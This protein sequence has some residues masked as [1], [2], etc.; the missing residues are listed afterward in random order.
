M[1]NDSSGARQPAGPISGG[2]GRISCAMDAVK[3]E[4]SHAALLLLKAAYDEEVRPKSCEQF[5]SRPMDAQTP[6][7]SHV[8]PGAAHN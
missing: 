5:A 2:A 6:L 4:H 7:E 8:Y 3:G 1:P